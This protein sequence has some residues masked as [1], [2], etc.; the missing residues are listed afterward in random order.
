MPSAP[1]AVGFLDDLIRSEFAPARRFF[2]DLVSSAIHTG[3]SVPVVRLS[4]DDAALLRHYGFDLDRWYAELGL[5]SGYIAEE[6]WI[7]RYFRIPDTARQRAVDLCVRFDVVFTYEAPAWL[8]AALADADCVHLDLRLASLRFLPDLL[9]AVRCHQPAIREALRGRMVHDCEIMHE[10]SLFAASLR[11]ARLLCP[12][13][14]DGSLLLL[15]Q[16]R[17]D[18]SLI[19]SSGKALTFHD[20]REQLAAL[21]DS[22]AAVYYKPHPFASRWQNEDDF[23]LLRKIFQ[24]VRPHNG[25]VYETFACSQDLRCCAISSGSVSEAACFGHQACYLFQP[26]YSWWSGDSDWLLK[27]EAKRS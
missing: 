1:L 3:T 6:D 4:T 10:A 7:A 19:D 12:L 22:S 18:A 16:L 5:K 13:L 17:G 2:F 21:C 24:N 14:P 20:F 27:S 25:N 15:G 9:V 11:H 23:Q 26:I 8:T